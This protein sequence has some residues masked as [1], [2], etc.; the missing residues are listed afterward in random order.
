MKKLDKLGNRLLGAIVPKTTAAAS[1][2]P[3]CSY[4]WCCSR[5]GGNT[6]SLVEIC[7]TYECNYT[8]QCTNYAC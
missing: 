4:D 3:Y 1:C 7:R 2:T 5:D 6:W 8:Q